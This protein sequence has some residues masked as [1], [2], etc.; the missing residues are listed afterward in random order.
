M[1]LYNYYLLEVTGLYHAQRS[2]LFTGAGNVKRRHKWVQC[3]QQ[4]ATLTYDL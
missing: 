2:L 4:L 3:E 1:T